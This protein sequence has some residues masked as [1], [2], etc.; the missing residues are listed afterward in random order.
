MVFGIKTTKP[1]SKKKTKGKGT[2]KTKT[3]KLK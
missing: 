3:A 2:K 1:L